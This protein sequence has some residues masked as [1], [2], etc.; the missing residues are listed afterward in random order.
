M[1]DPFE[2]GELDPFELDF[3]TTDPFELESFEP[4]PFEPKP[5]EPKPWESG[6]D[7]DEVKPFDDGTASYAACA[8]I[9]FFTQGGR[10]ASVLYNCTLTLYYLLLIRYSWKESRIRKAAEPYLHIIPLLLGWSTAIVGVATRSFNIT[11]TGCDFAS[12]P[13]GCFGSDR[14]TRARYGEE[15]LK[16][17]FIFPLW[18]VWAFLIVGMILI[19]MK[20]RAIEDNTNRHN[21]VLSI[22][23]ARQ[24]RTTR[25]SMISFVS[26]IGTRF[27]SPT[28]SPD[29]DSE[30]RS[31]D[32]TVAVQATA[33]ALAKKREK[34]RTFAKQALFYCFAFGISWIFFSLQVSFRFV[35]DLD[36]D[37][38]ALLFL[39]SILAPL[40]G[41]WN[42]IV[43]IRPQYLARRR[44]QKKKRLAEL[45]REEGRKRR[46]EQIAAYNQQPSEENRQSVTTGSHP[47]E[48]TPSTRKS[49]GFFNRR[50][51]SRLIALSK[52]IF[53]DCEDS[54]ELSESDL[55]DDDDGVEALRNELE[56]I[57]QV[58]RDNPDEEAN[59]SKNGGADDGE[60]DDKE[61][62]RFESSIEIVFERDSQFVERDSEAGEEEAN[63]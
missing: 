53:H 29:V 45:R 19:Y 36:I 2:S 48:D 9:G 50:G 4:D 11:P 41:F 30:R 52:A 47:S 27:S 1:L 58:P 63:K 7:S 37:F 16:Y 55:R 3:N 20:I 5:F 49:S 39:S 43:Y 17:F 12:Y 54:Q 31:S 13:P 44:T 18:A 14:C 38:L 40:Q 61:R 15:F 10:L 21:T 24:R 23:Q 26:S 56:G 28:P 46:E 34:S 57:K 25:I 8:A 6:F 22:A 42:A 33:D 32:H 51:S 62:N 35:L 60:Q 59:D